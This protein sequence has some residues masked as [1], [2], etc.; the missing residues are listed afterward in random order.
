MKRK[1]ATWRDAAR[2]RIAK[3]VAEVGTDDPERLR[4]AL[5]DAY[6]W[7]P[8]ENHPYRMWCEEMRKALNPEPKPTPLDI[9]NFWLKEHKHE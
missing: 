8:R 7:G 4:K 6:P 3:V 5:F 1:R 9:R 2:A